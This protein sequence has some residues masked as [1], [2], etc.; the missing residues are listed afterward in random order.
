MGYRIEQDSVYFE[1]GAHRIAY[2]LIDDLY[3]LWKGYDAMDE[4][5]NL[6]PLGPDG[7]PLLDQPQDIDGRPVPKQDED[8]IVEKKTGPMAWERRRLPLLQP[9][10][11][12]RMF[13]PDGTPVHGGAHFQAKDLPFIN[14]NGQYTVDVDVLKKTKVGRNQ[15]CP[16]GSGKKY[17]ACCIDRDGKPL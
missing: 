17:K 5:G 9:G 6:Y 13:E 16:C 10:D 14:N 15:R 4:N 8:R 1:H 12:F 2:A 7:R 11:V 3:D